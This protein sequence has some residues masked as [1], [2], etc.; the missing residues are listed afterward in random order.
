MKKVEL[1]KCA[2]TDLRARYSRHLDNN[3]IIIYSVAP[4]Q[5]LVHGNDPLIPVKEYI[6]KTEGEEVE[7]SVHENSAKGFEEVKP[8]S[9][10]IFKDRL[11][12]KIEKALR[13]VERQNTL[14]QYNDLSSNSKFTMFKFNLGRLFNRFIV[15]PINAFLVKRQNL[16][17]AFV[18]TDI[19]GR[20]ALKPEVSAILIDPVQDPEN[21]EWIRRVSPAHYLSV[22]AVSSKMEE[23]VQAL[24]NDL[25]ILYKNKLI[26]GSLTMPSMAM[27]ANVRG[28]KENTFVVFCMFYP[29][30][31][32]LQKMI[33]SNDMN[34]NSNEELAKLGVKYLTN[35]GG[36]AY[37]NDKAPGDEYEIEEIDVI[38]PNNHAELVAA[39][40]ND[41]RAVVQNAA[42]QNLEFLNFIEENPEVR[43]AVLEVITNRGE[44]NE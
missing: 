8:I 39:A 34:Y 29:D 37:L 27:L 42:N 4:I 14:Y 32:K 28:L 31:F 5:Y 17:E 11:G 10:L 6:E 30:L 38:V 1:I 13:R 12:K 18:E 33:N 2:I 44:N 9:N 25:I 3:K 19:M 16:E 23:A 41:T 21:F 43:R 7:I 35:E 24:K 15:H 22:S 36:V 26:L 40:Y 20:V